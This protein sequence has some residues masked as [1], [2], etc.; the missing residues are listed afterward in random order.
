MDLFHLV[1]LIFAR[2]KVYCK[3][4][5]PVALTRQEGP[6]MLT[7]QAVWALELVQV[8]K[9]YRVAHEMIQRLIH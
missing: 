2:K 1:P 4:H 3:F 8:G 5:S 9:I 7:R 6:Q